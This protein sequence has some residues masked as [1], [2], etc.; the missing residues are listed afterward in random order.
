MEKTK[1]TLIAAFAAVNAWL[2]NLAIPVYILVLLNIADYI[3]G[4][5]AAPY[6]GQERKS[7]VGLRGIAKKVSMWLLVGLGAAVDWLLAYSVGT[8]GIT[9]PFSFAVASLVA[10]WLIA[11]EIISILENVGD[12][13]VAAPPF[14][15]A[16]VKWVKAG[17]E[18]AAKQE[19]DNA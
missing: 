2:G 14:L 17:A 19:D 7:S 5:V 8:I 3:T 4:Y 10:I 12:I 1:I 13:G 6:R 15:M 9:L 11:N 16:L 18:K